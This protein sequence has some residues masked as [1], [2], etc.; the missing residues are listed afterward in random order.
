MLGNAT[1]ISGCTCV[2]SFLSILK[3]L[4]GQLQLHHIGFHHL[5]FV[6][7]LPSQGG[8]VGIVIGGMLNGAGDL[9]Y[10]CTEALDEIRGAV[11]GDFWQ[12]GAC[13]ACSIHVLE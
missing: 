8:R 12:V 3:G 2:F 7:P 5:K 11:Q 9:G 13:C 10:P 6:W 4:Q 1:Y